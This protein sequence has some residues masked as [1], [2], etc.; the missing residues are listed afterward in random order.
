[1]K[2]LLLTMIIL[3]MV[4]TVFIGIGCKEE[5]TEKVEDTT[6]ETAQIEETAEEAIQVEETDE[7]VVED[8]Y[9]I[10]IVG[11]NLAD[12]YAKWLMN[13]F[14]L[15]V[16][17][18]FPNIELTILDGEGS[19]EGSLSAMEQAIVLQPDGII[20]QP[21][22]IDAQVESVKSATDAGIPVVATNQRINDD[23]TPFVSTDFYAEGLALGEYFAEN[24]KEN[25]KV[26]IIKGSPIPP[27]MDRRQGVQENLLDKREDVELLDE[28]FANWS[29]EEA[30]KIM[31]DWLQKFPE[32]DGIIAQSD[33]MALGAVEAIR[34]IRE[35][36]FGTV[37]I[38]GNDGSPQGCAAIQANEYTAS[39][40]N[41]V[42]LMAKMT[43]DK[44]LAELKGEDYEAFE[45]LPVDMVTI[46]NVD[47][48]IQIHKDTDHWELD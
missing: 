22:D 6:E 17:S 37:I 4:A 15:Y 7:E 45:Y 11:W 21:I 41:D 46:D 28:Q 48:I 33:E 29:K 38:G 12:Q 8:S 44:L 9:K 16:E 3:C 19:L 26:V 34:G 23:K 20:I 2:K 13:S 1:M 24:I 42:P 31:E 35:D 43:L 40:W 10:I 32:I 27:A 5:A 25:A 30:L 18:E 47:E 36:M 39:V 14:T